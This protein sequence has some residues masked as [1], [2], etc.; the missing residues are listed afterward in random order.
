MSDLVAEPIEPHP[1]RQQKSLFKL[2]YDELGQPSKR[3]VIFVHR[4]IIIH[5]PNSSKVK[6][7]PPERYSSLPI[8]ARCTR[9]YA[10]FENRLIIHI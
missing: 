10:G 5:L 7:C 8:C 2:S 1:K 9:I 3:P 6:L 4:G